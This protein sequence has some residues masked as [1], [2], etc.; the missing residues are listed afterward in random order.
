MKVDE[1]SVW[2]SGVGRLSAEQRREVAAALA[3]RDGGLGMAGLGWRAWA[4]GREGGFRGRRGDG[5]RREAGL[6]SGCFGNERP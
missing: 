4:G 2:F 6:S 3:H 1:F 5:Q